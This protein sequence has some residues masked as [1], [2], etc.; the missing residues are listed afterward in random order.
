MSDPAGQE[1]GGR[2]TAFIS[3]AHE[4]ASWTAAK[5]AAW[6]ETVLAFA[7]A[8]RDPGGVDADLDLWHLTDHHKWRTFVTRAIRDSDFVL[9]AVSKAY[10]ERWEGTNDPHEGAGAVLEANVLQGL[11]TG[12][13][14][15]VWY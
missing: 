4:H 6:R 11:E 1:S 14:G 10:R 13:D 8:L 3:W 15:F 9:I 7:T 5:I 2:P 12:E